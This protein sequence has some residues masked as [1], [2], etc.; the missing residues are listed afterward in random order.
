MRIQPHQDWVSIG[1]ELVGQILIFWLIAQSH[2]N[3]APL[4]FCIFHCAVHTVHTVRPAHCTTHFAHC[5]LWNLQVQGFRVGGF[6]WTTSVSW[7]IYGTAQRSISKEL[8][9]QKT[10]CLNSFEAIHFSPLF[11]MANLA[12]FIA[13]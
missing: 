3:T 4:A 8:R 2:T 5:V 7:S 13:F 9:L 10:Q 1:T 11:A 12:C 6:P